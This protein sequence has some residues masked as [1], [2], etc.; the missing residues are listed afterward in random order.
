VVILIHGLGMDRWMW[1]NPSR[2]RILGGSLPISILLTGPP[3][4]KDYGY[5][6]KK[7]FSP[8]PGIT[9]G[10]SPRSLKTIFHDLSAE[11]YPIITWS[12]KRPTGPLEVAISELSEV[13]PVALRLSR[14]GIVLIGH[15]RGGLIARK[16]LKD[17]SNKTKG[18]ITISTPHSGSSIARLT[19]YV[20]PL[21]S[22]ISPFFK[23][24]SHSSGLRSASKR[25]IDFLSS[26][27]VK[28][29]L[30]DSGLIREISDQKQR[31]VLCMTVGGTSPSLYCLYR[32]KWETIKDNSHKRWVLSSEK[33]FS[34][35]DILEK[36]MPE[37]F[38]PGEIRQGFG[39]GLVTE[40]SSKISW[41]DNH[42]AFPCNH[43]EILF[44]IQARKA[45]MN[46]VRSIP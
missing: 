1:E 45:V 13:V 10:S 33:I 27:G 32:W 20:A 39:D 9:T 7:P 44:D 26:T 22:A 18:L 3:Y 24:S 8:L 40:E 14:N 28:E 36:I 41:C 29:L 21:V 30:P 42:Y 16:Y 46:T 5:S 31:G 38:I 2:S 35:P 6:E 34:I 15:S 4:K 12:Q 19:Q 37:A 25:V 11:D 17:N 43:A 23:E